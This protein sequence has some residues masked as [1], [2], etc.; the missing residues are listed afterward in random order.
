MEDG[1][2]PRDLEDQPTEKQA[3]FDPKIVRIMTDWLEQQQRKPAG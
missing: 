2:K 3:L 1:A